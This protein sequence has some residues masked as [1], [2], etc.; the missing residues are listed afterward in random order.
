MPAIDGEDI[1][2][3]AHLEEESVV[4]AVLGQVPDPGGDRLG[5]RPGV[6]RAGPDVNFARHAGSGAEDPQRQLGAPGPDQPGQRDDLAGTGRRKRDVPEPRP[7]SRPVCGVAQ[8]ADLQRDRRVGRRASRAAA[9]EGRGR[10]R[11][12]A[13]RDPRASPRST[14]NVPSPE[15]SLSTVTRSAMWKTSSSR[16][17]M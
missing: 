7:N 2:G 9:G 3:D 16:C 8:A 5:R 4:L 10:G 14:R 15:P 17:E 1:V 6:D 11:P 12:S 13:R